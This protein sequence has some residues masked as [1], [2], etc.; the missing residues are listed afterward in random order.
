MKYKIN[1][2]DDEKSLNDLVRAYLEKKI[3]LFIHFIH[4]MKL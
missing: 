4:M 3:L 2:I 1:I